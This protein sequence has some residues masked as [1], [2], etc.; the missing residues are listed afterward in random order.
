M[1]PFRH[2]EVSILCVRS[3]IFYFYRRL[4]SPIVGLRKDLQFL[5]GKI[6]RYEY[7]IRGS[8]HA[9]LWTPGLAA[10]ARSKLK[11]A[12]NATK[13]DHVLQP[14]LRLHNRFGAFD[15]SITTCKLTTADKMKILRLIP[16]TERAHCDG[17]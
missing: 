4:I 13:L 10:Y 16:H 2:F 7:E 14:E 11:T 17:V 15:V 6:S 8:L 3:F 9:P 1:T 5:L 12:S